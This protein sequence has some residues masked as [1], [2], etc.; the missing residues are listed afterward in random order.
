M[1]LKVNEMYKTDT[2]YIV[3]L[4]HFTK[5]AGAKYAIVRVLTYRE[6]TYLVKH[7]TFNQQDFRDAL[8]LKQNE[9]IEI[10]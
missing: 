8:H 3:P 2:G 6:Y 10:I 7:V 5:E 4:S 9:R 1:K